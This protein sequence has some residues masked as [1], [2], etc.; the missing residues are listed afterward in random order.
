[1]NETT[2]TSQTKFSIPENTEFIEQTMENGVLVTKFIPKECVSDL[3]CYRIKNHPSD[4][5]AIFKNLKSAYCLINADN[6]IVVLID[7]EWDFDKRWSKI[8]RK[9]M[10]SELAKYGKVFDFENKVLKD[11]KWR[12]DKNKT[13]YAMDCTFEVCNMEDNRDVIDNDNFNASNY[14]RTQQECQ[15]FCNKVKQ[16]LK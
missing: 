1:M 2:R 15:E 5:F 9:E 16:L 14:F 6:E 8:T 4:V 10:Q 11:L 13:Y 12:A 7:D 3:D